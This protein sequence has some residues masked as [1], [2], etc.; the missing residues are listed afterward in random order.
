MHSSNL[1]RAQKK[2]SSESARTI[3]N[4]IYS[5]RIVKWHT[6]PTLYDYGKVWH[7]CALRLPGSYLFPLVDNGMWWR[8]VKGG[9]WNFGFPFALSV[10]CKVEP[11]RSVMVSRPQTAC[12]L[13][14]SMLALP[15]SVE[16]AHLCVLIARIL[17]L[18]PRY[19]SVV[20][21]LPVG[22]TVALRS[23]FSW[24][25]NTLYWR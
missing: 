22:T 6:S 14:I 10:I 1:N 7:P 24:S 25:V 17:P 5:Q 8:G 12:S 4:R 13:F 3:H 16:H 9:C 2:Y 19:A 21:K 15:L 20:C 23:T 18:I 11:S